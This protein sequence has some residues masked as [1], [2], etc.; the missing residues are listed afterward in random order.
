[1][2]RGV[3]LVY[4]GNQGQLSMISGA[5]GADPNQIALNFQGASARIIKMIRKVARAIWSDDRLGRSS[6]PCSSRLSAGYDGI[7]RIGGQRRDEVQGSFR[8]L[9]TIKL[10]SLLATTITAANW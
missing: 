10:A 7:G 9:A 5:P 6:L 2:Y 8:Q 1:V 3:D 4:Y